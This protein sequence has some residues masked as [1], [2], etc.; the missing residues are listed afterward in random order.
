MQQARRATA[1]ESEG[2]RP[3]QAFRETSPAD[4]DVAIAGRQ[5]GFAQGHDK[6]EHVGTRMV[7]D[8]TKMIDALRTLAESQGVPVPHAV[9]RRKSAQLQNLR[10][11]SKGKFQQKYLMDQQKA[12]HQMIELF[13]KEARSGGDP[14]LKSFAAMTLK[15]LQT[16]QHLIKSVLKQEA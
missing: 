8:D 14:K 15:K 12:Q 10:G 13:T 6:V 9:A 11:M 3:G 4:R 2:Q 1:S 16:N 5:A 7:A